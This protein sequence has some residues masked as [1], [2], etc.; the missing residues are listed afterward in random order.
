MIAALEADRVLAAVEVWASGARSRR[1][2][3]AATLYRSGEYLGMLK[4]ELFRLGWMVREVESGVWPRRFALPLGKQGR[5]GPHTG[6]HR[7]REAGTLVTGAHQRLES[8]KAATA[9]Q[10]ERRVALA[11]AMLIAAWGAHGA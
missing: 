5:G 7:V 2:Y 4:G 11:E 8:M 9:A 6:A 1:R 10:R 3:T